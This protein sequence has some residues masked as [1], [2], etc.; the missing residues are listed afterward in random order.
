MNIYTIVITLHNIVRWFV[1]ILG[2]IA[3]LMALAG[4]IRKRTWGQS[5]RKIS[6]FYTIAIDIQ[7][8][9]GLALFLFFSPNTTRAFQDFS[10][11]MGNETARFYVLEHTILMILAVVLVHLG[12]ALTKKDIP[13][14]LKFR[15]AAIL[16]GLA[17]LAIV[18]GMPWD[19]P[20]IPGFG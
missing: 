18:L 7:L 15:R 4:W 12:S 8:L 1:L 3:F 11:I 6:T 19:R 5:D 13:D 14:N 17:L 10:G 16:F 9:L 20:L 2:I